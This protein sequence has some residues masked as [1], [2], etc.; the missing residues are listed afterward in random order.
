M[1]NTKTNPIKIAA[2]LSSKYLRFSLT[3]CT[4]LNFKRLFVAEAAD[5]A[6]V[7]IAAAVFPD[8]S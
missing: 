4:C 6:K 3:L 8:T 7:R 2:R 1:R 5:A